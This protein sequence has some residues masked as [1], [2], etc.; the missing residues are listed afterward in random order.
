MVAA[1]RGSQ[2]WKYKKALPSRDSSLASLGTWK[3]TRCWLLETQRSYG[4]EHS[5]ICPSYIDLILRL[6]I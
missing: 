2:G 4:E 1:S 3:A 5:L 6:T